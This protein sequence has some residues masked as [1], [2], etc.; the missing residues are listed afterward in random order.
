HPYEFEIRL[1]N[2][3]RVRLAGNPGLRRKEGSNQEDA[4][5]TDMIRHCRDRLAKP[6]LRLGIGDRAEEAG[7]HIKLPPQREVNH[8]SLV[9][10]DIREARPGECEHLGVQVQP[11]IDE[12]IA[13]VW[14]MAPGATSDVEQRVA[15]R[16]LMLRNEPL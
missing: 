6:L 4:T 3:D 14:H 13:Q 1:V 7:Y 15:C 11:L 5:Y 8:V 12:V 9:K 2:E 16:A 10:G